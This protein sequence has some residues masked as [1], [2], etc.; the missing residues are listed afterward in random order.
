M[1]DEW[2]AN[3]DLWR[4]IARRY[5]DRSVVAAYDFVNEPYGDYKKDLRGEL[6]KLMPQLYR[7]VREVDDRHVVYFSGPLSG[8]ITFYGDPK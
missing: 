4:E 8:G 1:A 3:P 6:A 5:K 7:A 2:Y